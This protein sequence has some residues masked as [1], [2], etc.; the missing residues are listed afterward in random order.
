MGTEINLRVHCT[1]LKNDARHSLLTLKSLDKLP[2]QPLWMLLLN[3]LV[4]LTKLACR[5]AS[6]FDTGW[7][8]IESEEHV[9]YRSRTI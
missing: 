6:W 3:M 2:F 4:V 9:H 8:G 7:Q 1:V 5:L